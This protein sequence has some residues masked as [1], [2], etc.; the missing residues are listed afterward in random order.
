LGVVPLIV[1]LVVVPAP[2]VDENDPNPDDTALSVT[3][4]SDDA[5]TV[6]EKEVLGATVPK[7][8]AVDHAGGSGLLLTP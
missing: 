8:A 2:G 1:P 4:L 3:L 5:V 7:L 6:R